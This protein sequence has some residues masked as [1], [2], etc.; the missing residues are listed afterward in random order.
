MTFRMVALLRA[1]LMVF[2]AVALAGCAVDA[3][4][5]APEARVTIAA[6]AAS[7]PGAVVVAQ[8]PTLSEILDIILR[9]RPTATELTGNNRPGEFPAGSDEAH[10]SGILR[11]YT[12]DPGRADRIA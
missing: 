10:V 11:R 2:V 4:R 8:R 3:T 7:L 5:A 9:E 12:S 1:A 6:H